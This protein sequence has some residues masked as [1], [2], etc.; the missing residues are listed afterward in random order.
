MSKRIFVDTNVLVYATIDAASLHGLARDTLDQAWE[1]G[2]DLV[3]S[4]QVIR[5]YIANTTRPQTYQPPLPRGAVLK[6]V[7]SFQKAF[8]VLPDS[9]E[10]LRHLIDLVRQIEVGGKQVHDTNIVATMLAFGIDGL[11]THNVSDFQRYSGQISIIP[12]EQQP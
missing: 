6:Q 12:L 8:T 1:D 10:V 11:L 2:H 7:E 3:I 4:H 5:E 9:D